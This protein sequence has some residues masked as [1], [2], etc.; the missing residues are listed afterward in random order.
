MILPVLTS[1]LRAEAVIL[2]ALAISQSMAVL[3]PQ[4]QQLATFSIP[5]LQPLTSAAA[6]R[7]T[8]WAQ[9]Q[10]LA[11]SVV[12]LSTSQMLQRLTLRGR[13]RQLILSRLSP[14][15]VQPV[16]QSVILLIFKPTERSLLSA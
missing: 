9:Q 15:P 4:H 3:S 8:L 7:P 5:M 16:S 1:Q 6:Q 11:I 10:Q 14:V 2:P 13:S 12:P